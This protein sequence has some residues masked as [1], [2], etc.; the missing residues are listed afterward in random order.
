MLRASARRLT[1]ILLIL[2]A[3][4][5]TTGVI[6]EGSAPAAANRAAPAAANPQATAT[7]AD[8]GH[9]SGESGATAS[10]S[11]PPTEADHSESGT[12]GETSAERGA[13]HAETLLGVNP[14]SI[15]LVVVAVL[16][17]LVLAAA[18]IGVRSRGLLPGVA[19]IMVA[20]VALDIREITHQVS[21]SRP[22][23]AALAATVAL[24]HLLA[25][26]SAL[27]AWRAALHPPMRSQPATR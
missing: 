11:A 23:L 9:D 7:P 26:A 2:S 27:Q 17:S 16:L 10:P 22:G 13:A 20:F 3:A 6:L 1:V 12:G 5:F 4:A 8:G 18:V 14:E 24:L 21:E 15:P 25:A 19:V